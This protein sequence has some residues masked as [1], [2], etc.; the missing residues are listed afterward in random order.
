MIEIEARTKDLEM[1]LA[2][3]ASA[4]RVD[5]GQVVKQEAQYLLQTL[6]KFTPPKSRPQ[7]NAAVARDMN[8]LTTPFAHRYFQERQTEGGFYKSIARYVRTR[9]SGKLQALFNNANLKG[10]YGLQLLTTKQEILNIH[11]QRRNNRG[12]VESGK[13]QYASYI[14]DAKAVRKEIQSRVGWTLSGWVPAAKATGARYL[15]FS[16]R[17]GAKSGTQS[18][19][20]NTPNPFIIGRNFNVKIPNYQS[21]VTSALRSRT[22]TT[23]K[24]LERVLAGRAVN[25]GFIRVQGNGAVPA[26]TPPTPTA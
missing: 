14:A 9:E 10:F 3:L 20:F 21:K 4:A 7:G 1:A 23:V 6:L 16:D 12:R 18:S 5:Y 15:K 17:F 24:K 19:N 8:N 2:R 11:K 22:G 25:L 13:K 26:A